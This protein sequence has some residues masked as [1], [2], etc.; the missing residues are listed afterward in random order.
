M[1]IWRKPNG[2]RTESWRIPDGNKAETEW[3]PDGNRGG[4]R[5]GKPGLE[6]GRET[7]RKSGRIPIFTSDTELTIYGNQN[8][9]Y[10]NS[11]YINEVVNQ[12]TNTTIIN[13]YCV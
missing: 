2:N 1:E 10:H 4:N 11:K 3:K 5:G 8:L 9:K 6:T 12:G 7:W 13:H